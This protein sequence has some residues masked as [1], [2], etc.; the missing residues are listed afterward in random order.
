MPP[1][2]SKRAVR[3][4]FHQKCNLQHPRVQHCLAFFLTGRPSSDSSRKDVTK[5]DSLVRTRSLVTFFPF[6]GAR[7]LGFR[8]VASREKQIDSHLG[9]RFSWRS[10]PRKELHCQVRTRLS[11]L[12]AFAAALT[13][14]SVLD[15][16]PE[17]FHLESAVLRLACAMVTTCK[18]NATRLPWGVEKKALAQELL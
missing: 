1:H 13:S 5:D 14:G 4:R 6:L 15:S 18:S 10:W 12:A 17:S 8:P 2:A 7:T 16:N 3:A 11:G 9:L